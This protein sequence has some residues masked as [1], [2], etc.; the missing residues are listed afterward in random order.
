MPIKYKQLKTKKNMAQVITVTVVQRG[1][2]NAYPV[3][4]ASYVIPANGFVAFPNT[5]A[6]IDAAS[7]VL[8]RATG[9][10]QPPLTLYVTQDTGT[11]YEQANA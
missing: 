6:N 10:N 5:N 9:L 7:V 11:L 2:Y 4:N 1:T 8:V 3:N